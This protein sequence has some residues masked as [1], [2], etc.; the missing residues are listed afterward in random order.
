M[1]LI[2][3]SCAVAEGLK[4]QE[5]HNVADA[6]GSDGRFGRA[7]HGEVKDAQE[8]LQGGLVHD[9]HHGHL[10]DQEVQHRATSGHRTVLLPSSVDLHLGLFCYQQFVIDVLCSNFCGLQYLDQ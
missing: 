6:F 7:G 4:G 10:H 5:L 8:L 3:P 9:V 2:Q 1:H